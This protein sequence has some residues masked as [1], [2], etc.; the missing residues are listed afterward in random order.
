MG[1]DIYVMKCKRR[2]G[3]V[4]YTPSEFKHLGFKEAFDIANEQNLA[5]YKVT[6]EK[7]R[8]ALEKEL[9]KGDVAFATAYPK[10]V[11]KLFKYTSYPAFEFQ[12]YGVSYNYQLREESIAPTKAIFS[13]VFRDEIFDSLYAPSIA[14]FRKVN[15]IYAY[16]D[17]RG[18]LDHDAECAWLDMEDIEGLIRTCKKVLDEKDEDT[19]MELLPTTSGCFFGSTAYDKWYYADVRDCKKQMEKVLRGLKKDEQAFIHFSW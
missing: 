13:D 18:L 5:N 17:K 4:D 16:F 10:Q 2:K 3:N 1:L 14:Y 6:F 8:N 9:K 15:F 7:V 11:K 19:S 12:R